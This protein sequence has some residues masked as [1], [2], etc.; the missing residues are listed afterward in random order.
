MPFFYKLMDYEKYKEDWIEKISLTVSD[1]LLTCDSE[2]YG[3]IIIIIVFNPPKIHQHI[4]EYE[5]LTYEDV[6]S[7]NIVHIIETTFKKSDIVKI[8]LLY[9]LNQ[10]AR[11]KLEYIIENF[12]NNYE[13]HLNDNYDYDTFKRTEIMNNLYM[14]IT[15]ENFEQSIKE[16]GI[17]H[18][19]GYKIGDY[20]DSDSEDEDK[21]SDNDY[22]SEFEDF[23]NDDNIN[24][25]NDNAND[26]INN[27]DNLYDDNLYAD[28]LYAD[29][30]YADNLYDD[31]FNGGKKNKKIYKL[32]K[33]KSIKNKSRK[34]KSRKNNLIKNK[35]IK[36]KSRKNNLIKN[37]SRKNNLIKNK[38]IKNKLIKNNLIK[39]ESIKNK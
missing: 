10:Y 6:P 9:Y 3:N 18:N 26:N 22:M 11:N 13:D 29:N 31:N 35:S 16:N 7:S 25:N 1:F 2:G 34:N 5:Y 30:L 15:C 8:D 23:V 12:I 28:N 24:N 39:N 20:E 19:S 17:L 32:K 14:H 21:N 37:K 33:N 27:A 4:H 36:N 38:S